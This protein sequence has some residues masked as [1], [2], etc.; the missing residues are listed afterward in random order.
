M[1][2]PQ[3]HLASAAASVS[4]SIVTGASSL[5]RRRSARV[6]PLQA[7]YFGLGLVE[8][9]ATMVQLDILHPWAH[10]SVHRDQ[11]AESGAAR[12]S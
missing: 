4:T 10:A 5:A 12:P 1:S 8:L 3:C 9:A 11:A 6:S 2:P 7:V